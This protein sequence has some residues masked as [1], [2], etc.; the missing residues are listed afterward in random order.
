[1]KETNIK[2]VAILGTESSHARAFAR[3]LQGSRTVRLIG[4]YGAEEAANRGF[5]EAFG[6]ECSAAPDAFCGEVD[7]VLITAR[8]G[9]DHLALAR[10][11]LRPGQTV[12]VDKPLC[13]DPHEADEVIALARENRAKLCGGSCLKFATPLLRL[14][15]SVE[16]DPDGVVG[17]SFSAPVEMQSTYGGF[18]FYAPHLIE[19]ALTVLKAP[20][21]SVRAIRQG[22]IVTALLRYDRFCA[23]LFFGCD[24]YTAAVSFRICGRH[25]EVRLDSIPSLYAKE[26]SHFCRLLSAPPEEAA[27]FPALAEHV[28]VAD[29]IRKAYETDT[30]ILLP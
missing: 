14:R 17:A 21:R 20:I 2:R 11:Y 10:P 5:R 12:F 24:A 8:N 18:L 7:G 30:E 27:D 23:S 19:M 1:M 26:L 9:A 29:A 6:V 3:L 13:N 16:D 28:R 22:D 15:A 4:A 25:C